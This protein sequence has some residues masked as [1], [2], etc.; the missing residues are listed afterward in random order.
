MNKLMAMAGF[1]ALALSPS[2][3]DW[4]QEEGGRRG[5]IIIYYVIA[6]ALVYAGLW[7][8]DE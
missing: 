1:L 4:Q 2:F 8:Y 7:G 3:I 5:H 6:M